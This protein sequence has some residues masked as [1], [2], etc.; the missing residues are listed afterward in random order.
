VVGGGAAAAVTVPVLLHLVVIAWVA[1]GAFVPLVWRARDV[2][3][4]EA[5][6]VA[7]AVPGPARS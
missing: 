2:K 6:G 3:E 4:G 1:L 7:D 5:H